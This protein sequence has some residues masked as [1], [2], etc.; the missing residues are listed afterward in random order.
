LQASS[1]IQEGVRKCPF[2]IRKILQIRQIRNA[3]DA[4]DADAVGE[5]KVRP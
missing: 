1:F 5:S 3:V 4:V 2:L